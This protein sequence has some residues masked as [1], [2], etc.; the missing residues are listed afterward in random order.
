MVICE[1]V[2]TEVSAVPPM[3]RQVPDA[4]KVA[5]LPLE[6]VLTN[7]E[8]ATVEPIATL[9]PEVEATQVEPMALKVLSTI[10]PVA[11]FRDVT[12][13]AGNAVDVQAVPF[14]VRTLPDVPGAVKP[15]PPLAAAKVPVTPVVIGK[16]VQFVN[17]PE[18]GVPNAPPDAN[19]V[20][21]VA[22]S[23]STVVPAIAGALSVTVPLVSPAIT[24]ELI[25]F[26]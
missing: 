24:T 7:P 4:P 17:V 25:L 2:P 18:A 9:A 20:P 16:P 21:L 1:K 13:P 11:P 14:D 12:P 8:P 19:I 3:F 26:S 5:L 10:A 23:V 15:V 22:G 6:F